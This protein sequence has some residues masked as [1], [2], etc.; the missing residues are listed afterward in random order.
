VAKILRY[1][2]GRGIGNL[3]L[4][5]AFAR[6]TKHPQKYEPLPKALPQH[7]F[8]STSKT[9]RLRTSSG[10]LPDLDIPEVG[11]VIGKFRL[12]KLLGVGA[13]AAV[14]RASHLVLGMSVAL[15]F[16]R[17]RRDGKSASSVKSSIKQL[18][19]EARLAARISHPNV[20]RILD[21]VDTGELPYIVMEY[22]NGVPLSDLMRDKKV[23]LSVAL[24]AA[25]DV[26]HGLEAGSEH[27][28]VHR[29]VKPANILV[30]RRGSAKLVD[31]GL[32]TLTG[33]AQS[34]TLVGTP[35]YMAPEQATP[36]A[37]TFHADLYALGATLFHACT[38]QLPFTGKDSKELIAAKQRASLPPDPRK[39]L[40]T[41]PD[42]VAALIMQLLERTPEA[43]GE[44]L[45]AVIEQ[46]EELLLEEPWLE[47]SQ[48]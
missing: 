7:I 33:A 25:R 45:P 5:A 47:R 24:S 21:I 29:D 17:T 12:D 2:Q 15:K 23:S 13:F 31:F 22:V 39:I 41:M 3:S 19:D 34:S 27:N 30:D 32:A 18:H 1:D 42:S 40:P 43:R 46:V 48:E 20:V 16:L 38:G 36:K 9:S 10:K 26:A 37:I 11:A 35:A 8:R 4:D 14:Y 44:S 6:P 28:L